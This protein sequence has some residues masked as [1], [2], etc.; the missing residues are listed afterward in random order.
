MA[1]LT[2]TAK[3]VRPLP[4]A[5]V[6]DFIAG[7][8]VNVGDLV[9]VDSNGKVQ[10][11][12]A[13]AAGTAVAIGIAV[14][15]GSLGATA[16]ASG[17]VVSVVL[18]GAVNGFSSLTPGVKVYVSNTAGKCADAAGTVSKQIGLTIATDTILLL[19]TPAA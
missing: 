6:R 19:H 17:D 5:L 16:A 12:N 10:Q 8:T 14:A 3:S 2:I 18:V 7:G 4:N 15:V 9:Y 11:A 13:S 1:D